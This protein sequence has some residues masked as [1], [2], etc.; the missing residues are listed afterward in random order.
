[1]NKFFINYEVSEALISAIGSTILHSL[2]Q[3]VILAVSGGL[4]LVLGKRLSAALRYI[5][6]VGVLAVFL[7][8]VIATFVNTL[9]VARADLAIVETVVNS[10]DTISTDSKKGL[11]LDDV[12]ERIA[13]LFSSL[14]DYYGIIVLLW[15]IVVCIKS[16]KMC[17]DL[18]GIFH[19]KNNGLIATDMRW[20]RLV[21]SVCKGINVTQ[22][23]AFHESL[24]AKTPLIIGHFK[25]MILFPIG[26]VTS[27]STEQV[28]A[29]LAH[30]LAHVRRKD[31]IVNVVQSTIEVLFFFNPA[32]LW[33]SSL[34]RAERENCCDDI[35]VAYTGSK[36]VYVNALVHCE[37]YS[38]STPHLAVGLKGDRGT[39]IDRIKR[40]LKKERP[41]L[42]LV[43]RLVLVICLSCAMV[44]GI[45]LAINPISTYAKYK[46]P[47][48]EWTQDEPR[49]QV[50]KIV[51]ELIKRELIHDRKNF[52][53]RVTNEAL[54][55]NGKRQTEKIHRHIMQRFVRNPNHR[56]DFT[57][58]VKTD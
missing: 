57:Q 22:R 31:F 54:Y 35:A 43:E 18:Y 23:I 36:A 46:Y 32:V 21:D 28:E 44:V 51:E 58:T 16:I 25:P 29:V 40:L 8:S 38:M 37:E 1:M 34:I 55:I 24:L 30:E 50:D 10:L 13:Y 42:N 5:L 12:S 20:Q 48:I 47:I 7:L 45:A 17:M 56:L 6:L 33:L 4:V 39:L 27:L 9:P 2:W 15:F 26:L 3:G 49:V 41:T 52:R 14:R 11:T 53:L 19:L